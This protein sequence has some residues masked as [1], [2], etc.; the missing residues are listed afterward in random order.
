MH[1]DV[2]GWITE[3]GI[4][5]GYLFSSMGPLTPFCEDRKADKE[6]MS[7]GP[8]R[9]HSRTALYTGSATGPVFWM[10]SWYDLGMLSGR[11]TNAY[12]T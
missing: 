1:E 9:Q 2:S 12:I 8:P 6:D 4:M 11:M 7:T 5:G 3:Q 10:K